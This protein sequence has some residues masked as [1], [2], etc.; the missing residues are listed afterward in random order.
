MLVRKRRTLSQKIF[1]IERLVRS[2]QS[3]KTS[4]NFRRWKRRN[5]FIHDSVLCLTGNFQR[6]CSLPRM[7]SQINVQ[8]GLLCLAV[9][10]TYI[11]LRGKHKRSK[12][13]KLTSNQSFRRRKEENLSNF[14][15]SHFTTIKPIETFLSRIH[16]TKSTR[17]LN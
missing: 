11:K 12:N 7:F 16:W 4:T 15:L 5:F 10:V 2:N 17:K 14:F 13:L 1:R 3:H 6:N 9:D 8:N